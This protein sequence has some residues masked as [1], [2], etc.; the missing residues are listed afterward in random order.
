[1]RELYR[2]TLQYYLLKAEDT[3]KLCLEEIQ[4][5]DLRPPVRPA[6]TERVDPTSTLGT[7]KSLLDANG[8]VI[9][10]FFQW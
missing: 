6:S 7:T 3:K 4:L 5:I 10:V 8:R 9:F 1:M 2:D